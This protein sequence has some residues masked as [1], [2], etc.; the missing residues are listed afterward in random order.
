MNI[1]VIELVVTLR[2]VVP[3][4]VEVFVDVTKLVE[5]VKLVDTGG[6][7]VNVVVNVKTDTLPC[8]QIGGTMGTMDGPPAKHEARPGY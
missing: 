7:E 3:P 4:M 6:V 8:E 2:I 5:V 1:D